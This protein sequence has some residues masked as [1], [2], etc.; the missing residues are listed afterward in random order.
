MKKGYVIAKP[1]VRGSGVL[2]YQAYQSGTKLEKTNSF[3]DF[4]DVTRYLQKSLQITNKNTFAKGVSAGG[5][6]MGVMVNTYADL[7]E[8]IVLDRPFL[9]VS[10]SMADT[11]LLLTTLEYQEWGNPSDSTMSQFIKNYSPTNNTTSNS[12]VNVF[13]RG[14]YKDYI[15]PIEPILWYS[16]QLNCSNSNNLVLFKTSFTEDHYVPY[17]YSTFAEEFSFFEYCKKRKNE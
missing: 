2:G 9:N 16:N 4:A 1:A 8:G 12:N 7:F 17:M 15:T 5:L 6:I 13:I 10:E 3:T 14:S 11:T